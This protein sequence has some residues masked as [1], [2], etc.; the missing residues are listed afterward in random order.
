MKIV[1]IE[2]GKPV[3]R[4]AETGGHILT[5]SRDVHNAV[6][7]DINSDG[8]K[9][10]VTRQNGNVELYSGITGGHILTI[11][12]N[13]SHDAIQAQFAGDNILVTRANGKSQLYSGTTGGYIRPI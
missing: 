5:I 2:S 4:S 7:A 10:V 1:T 9:V 8:T 3:L 13:A 6:F 11:S 12:Y